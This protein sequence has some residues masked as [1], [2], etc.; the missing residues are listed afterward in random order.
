VRHQVDRI[1]QS[2]AFGGSE[3]LRNLFSFLAEHSIEKPNQVIKSRNT[4]L[5]Q[6]FWEDRR[7]SMPGWIPRSGSTRHAFGRNWPSTICPR[8]PTTPF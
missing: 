2:R 5:P 4:T 7:L 6:P 8:A 1:L 3:L